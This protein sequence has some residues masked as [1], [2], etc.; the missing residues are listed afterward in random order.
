LLFSRW[1]VTGITPSALLLY[2]NHPL[3]VTKKIIIIKLHSLFIDLAE[4]SIWAVN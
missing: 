4:L 2:I 1:N 3:P